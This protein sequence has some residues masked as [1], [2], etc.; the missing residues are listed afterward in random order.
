MNSYGVTNQMKA[1][2]RALLVEHGSISLDEH[3]P[4]TLTRIHQM[5]SKFR[6]LTGRQL[7]E[8]EAWKEPVSC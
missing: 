6:R 1:T 7:T 5:F 4:Q 8:I 2:E 3:S